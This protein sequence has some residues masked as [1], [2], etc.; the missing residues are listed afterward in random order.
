MLGGLAFA[1]SQTGGRED[2]YAEYEIGVDAKGLIQGLKVTWYTNG[3]SEW[4][5]TFAG[6]ALESADR[7]FVVLV[8]HRPIAT[9]PHRPSL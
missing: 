8:R 9:P 2:L 4:R 3:G 6:A 7:V 1:L 5:L